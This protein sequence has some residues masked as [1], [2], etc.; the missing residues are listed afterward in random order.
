MTRETVAQNMGDSGRINVSG[1]ELETLGADVGD[2][3][4]LNVADTKAIAHAL[5][6][7]K[8]TERFLIVTAV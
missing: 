2:D 8:A 5:I 6:D 7:S 1:A 3:I 4:E